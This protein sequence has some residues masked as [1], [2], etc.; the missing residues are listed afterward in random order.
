MSTDELCEPPTAKAFLKWFGSLSG[1]ALEKAIEKAF[2]QFD[3]DGSGL[4][5]R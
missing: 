3:E 1:P 2:R 5:D 4:I